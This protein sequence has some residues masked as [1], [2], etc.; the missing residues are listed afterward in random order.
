MIVLAKSALGHSLKRVASCTSLRLRL[1]RE[2]GKEGKK[3]NAS[4]RESHQVINLTKVPSQVGHHTK[5]FL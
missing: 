3:S 1:R 4:L 2:E 5:A